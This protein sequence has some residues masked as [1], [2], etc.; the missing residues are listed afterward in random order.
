MSQEKKIVQTSER[1]KPNKSLNVLTSLEHDDIIL[2]DG[3]IIP[4]NHRQTS[5]YVIRTH[6]PQIPFG[7]GDGFKD[8]PARHNKWIEK[9][10]FWSEIKKPSSIITVLLLASAVGCG[11]TIATLEL[12]KR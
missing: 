9:I 10:M 4:Y 3:T 7:L 12:I 2:A 6:D 1:R 5:Q 11:L 8:I